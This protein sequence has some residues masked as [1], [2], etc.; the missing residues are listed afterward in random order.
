MS[1][2]ILFRSDSSSTIGTGHIMRD[3]VLANQYPNSK[4]FFATQ[5]LEGNLNSKIVE[6]G[7]ELINLSGNAIDELDSLI[8]K[9]NIDLLI[10]DH[11]EINY[12]DEKQLKTN[13]PSLKIL[14]F[15]DTYEKHYC[16]ILLNHNINANE[17]KYK[18]LVP[19]DCELRCGS[20][21][22]LLREEFRLEKKRKR[23]K[24]YDFF[25][26]MGGADTANLNIKILELLENDKKVALVTTNA[27]RNLKDL[28][29]Y[30]ENKKNISLFI[31]SNEMAK[32]INQSKL[33]IITPSV[34]VNEVYFLDTPFIAIKTADNQEDIYNSLKEKGHQVLSE[35]SEEALS[36]LL[37]IEL[38]NFTQL[39][40]DEKEL[41]LK[42]RND[43]RIRK[44]MFSTELISLENHLSYIESLSS[45]KDRVYFLVKKNSLPIGVIDFTEITT[46]SAHIGLY[47]NPDIK[48][49]GSLIMKE[50]V[51]YG[52]EKLKVKKLISEVFETN[53]KA[54][55]LYERFDF[56]VIEKKKDLLIMELNYENR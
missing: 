40:L 9:L 2:N 51:N 15:D 37:A 31:N 10:I 52:F 4:I 14:S 24:I 29:K 53:S 34:T 50:I 49:V 48:G 55:K 22:T 8:K 28:K 20:N 1:K 17:S 13:N 43:E 38:L 45:K 23:E 6:S 44:W 36:N 5:N 47:S 56:M 21:Y 42:W 18:D 30:V 33:V 46:S 16:D 27:N 3:L 41:V 25:I 12:K 7:Y 19:K 32:I 35:F 26:A 39:S 11:Y 54:I